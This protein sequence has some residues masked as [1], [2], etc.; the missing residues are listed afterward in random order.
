VNKMLIVML[1]GSDIE[2]KVY[3][4]LQSNVDSHLKLTELY[5]QILE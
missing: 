5:K 1:Q 4:A 3:K 2:R